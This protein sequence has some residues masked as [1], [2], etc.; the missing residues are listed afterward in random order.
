VAAAED[1]T[2]PDAGHAPQRRMRGRL[3]IP[4]PRRW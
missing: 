2:G 3:W 1:K 4:R